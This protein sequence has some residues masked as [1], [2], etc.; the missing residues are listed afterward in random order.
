MATHPRAGAPTTFTLFKTLLLVFMLAC[1]VVAQAPAPVNPQPGAGAVPQPTPETNDKRKNNKEGDRS[2]GAS[3]GNVGGGPI[4]TTVT[5]I[6]G[7][8]KI[9]TITPTATE[10]SAAGGVITGTPT[11]PKAVQSVLVVASTSFGRALPAA[12]PVNDEIESHFWD[13]FMPRPP[14]APSSAQGFHSQDRIASWLLTQMLV[15]GL[16]AAVHAI[17]ML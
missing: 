12:G 9:I 5:V 14:V 13:R 17:D 4:M 15:M 7:T 6:S 10:P 8:T 11:I 16:V 1:V 3:A 2:S